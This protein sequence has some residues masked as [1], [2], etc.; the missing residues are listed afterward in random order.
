[1]AYRNSVAYFGEVLG[2]GGLVAVRI[3]IFYQLYN[4]AFIIAGVSV[5][6]GLTLAETIWILALTQSF[7]VS[8][9]TRAV[10]KAIEDEVKSGSIAYTIS[11]PYSY[12]LYNYFTCMGI[13]ASHLFTSVLFGLLVATLLVGT[14]QFSLIG[15]LAGAFLLFFGITLNTLAVLII[16]LSAFWAEDTAPFRWIYDKMLWIFGG[17]FLPFSV[18]PDKYRTIIE[19]LP[20]N[21]MFYAPAR[22]I[23]SFNSHDFYKNLGI[24]IVWIVILSLLVRWMYKK[25]AEN[26]SVNAG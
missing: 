3:W 14:I 16:G 9:R 17:I 12:L 8:N 4:T 1:M 13:V 10:M 6:G 21:Q 15:L 23:V 24:Q 19:L 2:I 25:G 22:M 11:K 18:L 26:L 20:F 5:L 7:H